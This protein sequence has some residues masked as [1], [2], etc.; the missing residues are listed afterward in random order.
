FDQLLEELKK[1]ENLGRVR[2]I[3]VLELEDLE[4]AVLDLRLRQEPHQFLDQRHGLRIVTLDFQL[5]A[6]GLNLDRLVGP[7]KATSNPRTSSGT[8]VGRR[9]TSRSRRAPPAR[10][11]FARWSA[12]AVRSPIS[13]ATATW[14]WC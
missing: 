10:I 1:I 14:M 13:T 3:G 11:C 5:I 9:P 2:G 6:D 12:A 7:A 4:L 8:R